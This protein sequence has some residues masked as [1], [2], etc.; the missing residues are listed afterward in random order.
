MLVN[1]DFKNPVTVTVKTEGNL[2]KL[3]KTTGT[4]EPCDGTLTLNAGDGELIRVT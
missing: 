1:K 2:K 4:W 3:N